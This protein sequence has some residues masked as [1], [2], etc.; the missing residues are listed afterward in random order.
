MTAIIQ[1]SLSS[2]TANPTKAPYT[3]QIAVSVATQSPNGQRCDLVTRL[4]AAFLARYPSSTNSDCWDYV[5]HMGRS[6]AP[7]QRTTEKFVIF[8]PRSGA[9]PKTL[10][11]HQFAKRMHF[12]RRRVQSETKLDRSET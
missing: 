3:P 6:L 7:F 1:H 12:I 9:M 8:Q 11:R 4:A 5:V 2:G 10:T